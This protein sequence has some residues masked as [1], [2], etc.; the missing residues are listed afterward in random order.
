MQCVYCSPRFNGTLY[1]YVETTQPPR[2]LDVGERDAGFGGW[3]VVGGG[4]GLSCV[5]G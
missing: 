5:A 4:G 2:P 1:I 3:W